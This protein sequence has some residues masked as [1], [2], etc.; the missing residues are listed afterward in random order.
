MNRQRTTDIASVSG[1]RRCAGQ[2]FFDNDLSNKKDTAI[3]PNGC[4]VSFKEKEPITAF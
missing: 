4:R 1:V 2:A 3:P